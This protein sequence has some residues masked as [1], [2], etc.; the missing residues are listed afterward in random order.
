MDGSTSATTLDFRISCGL[1]SGAAPGTD[2]VLRLRTESQSTSEYLRH[3]IPYPAPGRGCGASYTWT[4][5]KPGT[6]YK[7]SA[8]VRNL[9]ARYGPWSDEVEGT[10][11]AMQQGGG[12]DPTVSLSASPNPVDE[13]SDVRVTATLSSTLSGDVTIPLSLSHG[14]ADDGDYGSLASITILGGFSSAT[15]TITTT[16]G[17]D[18]ATRRSPWRWVR[19]RRT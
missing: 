17:A 9:F 18:D 7:F 14:T 15:G 6:T 3:S 4:G 11:D 2:Y 1:H 12:S 5:L 16:D 8:R 13:G 10:T 19:C